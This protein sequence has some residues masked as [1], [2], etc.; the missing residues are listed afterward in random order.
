MNSVKGYHASVGYKNFV[1]TFGGQG[2]NNYCER[3]N[4]L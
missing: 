3:L 1:F 2:S 4:H